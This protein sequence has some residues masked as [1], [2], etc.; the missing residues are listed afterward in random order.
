MTDA[1]DAVNTPRQQ[2]EKK[3]PEPGTGHH[4]QTFL[5]GEEVYLRTFELGDE[6]NAASWRNSVFPKSTELVKT[7]I[8]AGIPKA[9]KQKKGFFAIVRKADDVL[10]GSISAGHQDVIV[11]LEAHV[12]PLYG[13]QGL[14][15]KAEAIT[16]VAGWEVD[17]RHMPSVGVEI[18]ASETIVT[19]ALRAF[20]MREMARWREMFLINGE[21][22]DCVMYQYHNAGWMETLGDPLEAPLERTGTGEPR[23]VPPKVTL[24][25]DP[26]K[27][28]IMVGKRVYLR[29]EEKDDAKSVAEWA[30][31]E[32]ET[33]FDIGRHLP[34]Q[35]L[36]QNWTQSAQEG[37]HPGTISFSVCLRESD[38]VIGS[39][40]L[41]DVNYVHLYAETGSFF[42]RP[43]YRGAGYGS[44]AKQLLLEYA[45]EKLGLHMVE[46]WVLFP[47]TRSAAALR[48]QGYREAGRVTWLYPYEGN[49]GN[50]VVFDLLAEEWRAMPRGE[51]DS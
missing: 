14:R 17:E 19:D 29:P 20:G 36:H 48:K 50:M 39:V 15:W 3:M 16:L 38:E 11:E 9:G 34:T 47:N 22:V 49:F 46:S 4:G 6:K 8:E 32:E 7:W 33:F 12:D 27:N 43:D 26:P 25:G 40:S 10:V 2:E 37:D 24:D 45:F 44:E 21:R 51:W 41:F 35:V 1:L 30:R 31:K 23:P 13:D 5:V 42:H 28:A 18:P